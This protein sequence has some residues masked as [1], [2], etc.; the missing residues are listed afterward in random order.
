MKP[1]E[2][3]LRSGEPVEDLG[4]ELLESAA[5]DDADGETLEERHQRRCHQGVQG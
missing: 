5:R 4:L 1:A 3:L 2:D